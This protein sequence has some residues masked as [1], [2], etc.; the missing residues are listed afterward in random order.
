MSFRMPLIALFLLSVSCQDDPARKVK[1]EARPTTSTSTS[2]PVSRNAPSEAALPRTLNSAGK[3]PATELG[4]A[5]SPLPAGVSVA[6]AKSSTLHSAHRPL[7]PPLVDGAEPKLEPHTP[8]LNQ[9]IGDCP[10]PA[11]DSPG[12]SSLIGEGPCQFEQKAQVSCEGSKDD[13]YA[14]FTRTAKNGATLVTYINV[15]NYH[16]PGEYEGAQMFVALQSG[17]SIVR[18]SSDTVHAT[19][20]ADE[21]FVDLPTTR[22]DA[23]PMLLDCS[24]LISASTNYQYQCAVRSAT[25]SE[26]MNAPEVVSGKLQCGEHAKD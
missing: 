10:P 7:D 5:T 2:E 22:L 8:S 9:Q 23:E 14:A 6:R 17:T 19:V 24:R 12:P 26:I 1:I 15:E 13:F 20:G 18:W 11:E 4:T 16:G 25:T 21:A 3:S